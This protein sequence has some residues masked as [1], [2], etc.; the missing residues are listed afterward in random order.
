[1]INLLDHFAK[2]LKN[3]LL[4]KNNGGV[5][6]NGPWINLK[7]NTLL[8]RW[9]INDFSSVDYTICID[10]NGNNK[11]IVKFL[12]TATTDTAKIVEYARNSTNIDIIA[13]DAFVNNSYVD[14]VVSPNITK[15]SGAK[16]FFTGQYFQAQTSG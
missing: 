4:F 7:E 13:I 15:A 11:E 6:H 12:I 3:T 10:L 5:S 16:V 9:H 14:V 2:G 1:M 8:D